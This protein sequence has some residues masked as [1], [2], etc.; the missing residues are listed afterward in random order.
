MPMALKSRITNE[1]AVRAQMAFDAEKRNWSIDRRNVITEQNKL[2]YKWVASRAERY[3][4]AERD[5][6]SEAYAHSFINIA[7]WRAALDT[8]VP[9]E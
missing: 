3:D 5:C 9:K 8:V 7:C 4:F 1:M 2:A 6:I